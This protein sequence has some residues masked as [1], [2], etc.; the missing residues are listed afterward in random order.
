MTSYCILIADHDRA[1]SDLV[2]STLAADGYNTNIASSSRDAITSATITQPQLLVINPAL[3]RPSGIEAA[4]QIHLNTHCKVLFVSAQADEPFFRAVLAGLQRQGCEST[5]LRVPFTGEEL[6]A[7]VKI[8][9]GPHSS[10]QQDNAPPASGQ[11]QYSAKPATPGAAHSRDDGLLA[12]MQP[13]LYTLNAFRVTGLDIDASPRDMARQAEKLEMLANA[14]VDAQSGDA[15]ALGSPSQ[16]QIQVA[17]QLLKIPEQRLLQEFFWFWPITS[18]SKTDDAL[19]ALHRGEPRLAEGLWT[20]AGVVQREL[21]SVQ[22]LLDA[23]CSEAEQATL[24]ARKSGLERAKAISMHNLAILHHLYALRWETGP[25]ADRLGQHAERLSEW[26]KAFAFW[27]MLRDHHGFWELLTERIRALGDTRLTIA[28]QVIW[29]S[30]P[31]GLLSINAELAATAVKEQN[32]E[33]ALEHRQ[34]M[35]ASALGPDCVTQALHSGL[36]SIKE[37]LACLCENAEASSR[38]NPSSGFPTVRR[39][40][41]EANRYL[42]GLRSLLDTGDSMR[43]EAHDMI[44]QSARTCLWACANKTQDWHVAQPLFQECFNLAEGNSLRFSLRQDLETIADKI[45]AQQDR[46]HSHSMSTMAEEMDRNKRGITAGSVVVLAVV[47]LISLFVALDRRASSEHP[48]AAQ[49]QTAAPQEAPP[50]PSVSSPHPSLYAAAQTSGATSSTPSGSTS[51]VDLSG[52]RRSIIHNTRQLNG[53]EPAL[54]N[55]KER[56]DMLRYAIADRTKGAANVASNDA[57]TRD[58]S[59]TAYNSLTRDYIAMV[60]RYKVLAQSTNAQIGSYNS[61]V[62]SQSDRLPSYRMKW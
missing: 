4:K 36:R 28:V 22:I 42:R 40:L 11:T 59:L 54:A 60:E 45:A 3:L 8:E 15:F 30:L 55:L 7:R 49:V 57:K 31:L 25:N 44:A 41:A 50:A 62:T 9:L 56:L 5:A 6:L 20:A 48:A 38:A 35:K 52:L 32:Y 17:M 18:D 21:E 19:C 51:S 16:E 39:L 46:T 12:M 53:M 37:E 10:P 2:S 61:L 13:Q 34:I 29:N 47:A 24:L 1:S 33:A 26:K 58:S 23:R 27:S 14:G 43:G